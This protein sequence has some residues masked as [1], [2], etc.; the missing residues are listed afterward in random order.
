V[1]SDKYSLVGSLLIRTNLQYHMKTILIVILSQLIIITNTLSQNAESDSLV[2]KNEIRLSETYDY[3]YAKKYV[4]PIDKYV[5]TIKLAKRQIE[6]YRFDTET[7]EVNKTEPDDAI[8]SKNIKVQTIAKFGDNYFILYKKENHSES[9]S[10]RFNSF[11]YRQIDLETGNIGEEVML[12]RMKT[13]SYDTYEYCFSKDTSFLM[14]YYLLDDEEESNSSK[15]KCIIYQ[16]DFEIF[17]QGTT[18]LPYDV[19]NETIEIIFVSNYATPYVVIK[20]DKIGSHKFVKIQLSR[21]QIDLYKP[22]EHAKWGKL[23]TYFNTKDRVDLVGTYD[24]GKQVFIQNLRD[25]EELDVITLPKNVYATIANKKH[26]RELLLHSTRSCKDGGMLVIM[27][28]YYKKVVRRYQEGYSSS[29]GWVAGGYYDGVEAYVKNRLLIKF[30]KNK[31]MKWV[32]NVPQKKQDQITRLKY[33]FINNQHYFFTIEKG[34]DNGSLS[35][36][37]SDELTKKEQ[38]NH[39]K[40]KKANLVKLCIV[41]DISGQYRLFDLFNADYQQGHE[42]DQLKLKNM[43]VTN[44]HM[45]STELILTNPKHAVMLSLPLKL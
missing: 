1:G 40:N 5:Y 7:N 41:D 37:P 38:E 2:N 26:F 14:V 23:Y 32:A 34:V 19:S 6:I 9:L 22:K 36:P 39:T 24:K 18:K 16:D 25:H 27:Q 44:N 29:R 33:Y 17:E 3:A 42:V 20:D 13:S 12:D 28:E 11:H 21:K 30:D 31:K 10:R 15:I 43:A 45:I 8:N 35:I 4:F